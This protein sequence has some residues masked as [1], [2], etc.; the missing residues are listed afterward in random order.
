MY[1]TE[2]ALFRASAD[3][4]FYLCAVLLGIEIG[5]NE[6]FHRTYITNG[7]SVL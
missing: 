3:V 7:A 1:R 4:I 2:S 6:P 5:P